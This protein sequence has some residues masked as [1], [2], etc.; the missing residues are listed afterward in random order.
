MVQP[1]EVKYRVIS[2]LK[3]SAVGRIGAQAVSWVVTLVIVRLLSPGDYGLMASA[4]VVVGFAMLI[5]ELGIIPALINA[6]EVHSGL[7]RQCLGFVIL[8][9]VALFGLVY[10][11]ASWCGAFFEEASLVPVI[12]VLAVTLL[13]NAASSVPSALLRRQIDFKSL[14]I[15][16]MIAGIAGSATSLGMAF[17]G[18]G[19]WAL[20]GGQVV[21]RIVNTVGVL[22]VSPERWLPSF[23]FAGLGS[24]LRYGA[25]VTGQRLLSHLNSQADVIIIG[26]LLGTT[27]LGVYFVAVQVSFLPISKL[28]PLLNLVAFPAFSRLQ[29]DAELAGNYFLRAVRI[30]LFI[31]IPMLWGLSAVA[32][33]FVTVIMGPT[34]TP[35]IPLLEVI[36][37]A[38]PVAVAMLMLPPL[39]NGMGR[40]DIGLQNAVTSIVVVP[41][42]ILIGLQ[43]GL[44][45]AS[46]GFAAG[47]TILT[48]IN[49]WRSLG[50]IR[51]G[52]WDF[53]VTVWPVV[54]AGALM[55]GIVKSVDHLLLSGLD[56][57][58]KLALLVLTG[59]AA[60]GMAALTLCRSIFRDLNAIRQMPKNPDALP[61][62][63]PDQ[64][65]A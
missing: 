36:A 55:Y 21:G 35:A 18:A 9:N 41:T 59:V 8:L 40:P 51:A 60:Y 15:V 56:P 16:G 53:V 4:M 34:W 5:H 10:G 43:W 26:K 27:Q 64:S 37:F 17:T 58:P 46:F 3:W 14:S 2:S 30:A 44:I 50:V 49:L 19:V 33:D 1:S 25:T 65:I 23:R 63:P 62:V 12:Q 52:L 29:E 54:C 11:T 61:V 38:A 42:C 28:V 20:V 39:L 24:H 57:L 32:H 22:W 47:Y 7:I 45:G 13:I 6:K 48:A 31:T